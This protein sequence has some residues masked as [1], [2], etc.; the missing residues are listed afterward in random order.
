MNCEYL[1]ADELQYELEVRDPYNVWEGHQERSVKEFIRSYMAKETTGEVPFP[2]TSKH[3]PEEQIS[4]CR[5]KFIELKRLY[6]E[7]EPS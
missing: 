4:I 3:K 2:T 1:L 7:Y 6:S 5:E